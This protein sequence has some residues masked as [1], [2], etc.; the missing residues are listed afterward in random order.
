VNLYYICQS[1]A[2]GCDTFDAMVVAAPDEQTARSIHPYGYTPDLERDIWYGPSGRTDEGIHG[3]WAR[4]PS[5]VKVQHIGAAV[6]GT[7][8]GVILSS[9]NAG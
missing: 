8:A 5:R 2:S 3:V 9:F 1:E 7:E 6:S 4:R